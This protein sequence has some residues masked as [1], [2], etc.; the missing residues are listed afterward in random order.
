MLQGL[1][2]VKETIELRKQDIENNDLETNSLLMDDVLL[3]F[4]Y[5]KRRD[6]GVKA[7]YAGGADW[8][9][10]EGSEVR[11]LIKVYGY[12]GEE[13]SGQQLSEVMSLASELDAR[14]VILTDGN[15]LSVYAEGSKILGI[16]TLFSDENDDKLQYLTNSG[17]DPDRL[18]AECTSVNITE[19]VSEYISSEA[20]IQSIINGLSLEDTDDTRANIRGIISSLGT[21]QTDNGDSSE[22]SESSEL[23]ESSELLELRAKISSQTTEL[24]E[25]RAELADTKAKLLDTE[26][27]LESASAASNQGDAEKIA[28]LNA[29]IEDLNAELQRVNNIVKESDNEIKRLQ[30]LQKSNAG[31]NGNYTEQTIVDSQEL[32][33]VWQELTQKTQE[34]ETA[35]QSND[36]LKQHI[37]ELNSEIEQ[38]QAGSANSDGIKAELEAL[39]NESAELE[40]LKNESA[41]LNN[42]ISSLNDEI[43]KLNTELSDAI[44]SRDSAIQDNDDIKKKL[45]DALQNNSKLQAEIEGLKVNGEVGQSDTS[46]LQQ[47]INEQASEISKLEQEL[48][49]AKEQLAANAAVTASTGKS[50]FSASEEEAYRRRVSDLLS[51]VQE[52]QQEL[53]DTNDELEKLRKEKEGAEDERVVMARQLLEAVE[54]N[55]DLNRTYIGVVNSKLFQI[56]DLPRFIGTCL[57]ELYAAVSFKLMPL[58]F[59]GDIFK[60]VQPAVRGDMMINT[61]RYDIDIDGYTEEELINKL[62]VLFAQFEDVV[63]MCKAIGTLREQPKEIEQQYREIDEPQFDSIPDFDTDSEQSGGIGQTTQSGEFMG[64]NSNGEGFEASDNSGF[65]VDNT[66]PEQG[67]FDNPEIGMEEPQVI[68]NETVLALALCD[69]GQILWS[70]NSPIHGLVAMANSYRIVKI[71]DNDISNTLGDSISALIGLSGNPLE[72]LDKVRNTDL[73][74]LT[75]IVKPVS[76]CGDSYIRILDTDYAIENATNQQIISFIITLAQQIGVGATDIYMYF[77]AD[78]IPGSTLEQNYV[79]YNDLGLGKMIENADIPLVNDTIHCLI[80]GKDIENIQNIQGVEEIEQR[81][82]N[83]V[84]AVGVS[85]FSTAIKNQTEFVDALQRIIESSESK[86]AEQIIEAINSRVHSKNPII[87]RDIKNVS[88]EAATLVVGNREYFIDEMSALTAAQVLM[89]ANIEATGSNLIDIRIDLNSSLYTALKDSP[90]TTDPYEF[91]GSQL[92]IATIASKTKTITRK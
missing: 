88:V 92:I 63:F 33:R 16:D 81:L 27:Q 19:K 23:A 56:G 40:A 77:L 9:I 72:S 26:A 85:G 47:R 59:D 75:G 10:S 70:D 42:T 50:G 7:V 1:E 87:A 69:V 36:E 67:Q 66:L 62:K 32:D 17:W 54:D 30:E 5:N 80:S 74:S 38:L 41:E 43:S 55:P 68:Q 51:Q 22:L 11:M 34:L 53:Q 79:N 6:K 91:A 64:G 39:K 25:V 86:G 58:L 48:H 73:V 49:R 8:E 29:E 31:E 90:I 76:E 14:F 45:D 2:Y 24:D 44:E 46:E 60:T 28:D 13:P 71:N 15:R 18:I 20:F 82:F 57:Q 12:N 78:Y 84:V 37:A 61:K 35:R 89:Y 83:K 52:L 3:A 4:G 21:M 65:D